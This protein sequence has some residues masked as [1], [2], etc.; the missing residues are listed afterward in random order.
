MTRQ[1]AIYNATGCKKK[2]KKKKQIRNL[3]NEQNCQ[4]N[5]ST[6]I[7]RLGKVINS[8]FWNSIQK[9]YPAKVANLH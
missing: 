2:K 9:K 7:Y 3:R 8:K 6:N 4:N 5:I 1:T